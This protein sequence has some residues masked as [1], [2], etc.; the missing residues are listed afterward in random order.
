MLNSAL[1]DGS[2]QRRVFPL[3]RN[4]GL[5]SNKLIALAWRFR[6][7]CPEKRANRRSTL[8]GKTGIFANDSSAPAKRWL[9]TCHP[10]R[11]ALHPAR[12]SK[13]G[14]STICA[15]LTDL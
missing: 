9:A 7:L 4:D 1:F 14:T 8:F 13:N 11:L 5:P 2:S 3:G 12:A 6:Q 15:S 10:E